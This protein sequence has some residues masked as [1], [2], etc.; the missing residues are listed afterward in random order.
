VGITLI[1]IS[2]ANPNK[3]VNP[4]LPKNLTKFYNDYSELV[5]SELSREIT[6]NYIEYIINREGIDTSKIIEIR[7]M[8]FPFGYSTAGMSDI[9]EKQHPLGI[10]LGHYVSTMGII[11]IYP[12]EFS[13]GSKISWFIDHKEA[14]YYFT[15]FEPLRTFIHELLLAKYLR[16]EGNVNTLTNKYM[17]HFERQTFGGIIFSDRKPF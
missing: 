8:R 5:Y 16:D 3:E 12:P 17:R 11:D 7:I 1:K 15:L 2:L 9:Q 14:G 4:K 10:T 13:H 6:Q